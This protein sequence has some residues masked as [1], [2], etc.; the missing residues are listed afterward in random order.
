MRPD[1][2]TM[3]NVPAIASFKLQ[4]VLGDFI[5]TLEAEKYKVFF[6]V[7]YSLSIAKKVEKKEYI[8]R[9]KECP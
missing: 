6:Q 1:I 9:C 5:Q 3:E 8:K 2:V 7:V 4:S